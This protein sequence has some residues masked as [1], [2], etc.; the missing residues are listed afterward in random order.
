MRYES[1]T[2]SKIQE[3]IKKIKPEYITNKTAS[4]TKEELHQIAN[5]LFREE[6][7]GGYTPSQIFSSQMGRDLFSWYG[8]EDYERR[9]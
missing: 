2:T 7:T 9:Y 6:Y 3:E 5:L 4:F 1:P 8:A